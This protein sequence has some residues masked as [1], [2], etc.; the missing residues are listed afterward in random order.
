MIISSRVLVIY[1][2][3]S[4]GYSGDTAMITHL[5][6]LLCSDK[7]GDGMAWKEVPTFGESRK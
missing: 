6:Q 5:K 1:C 3:Y 4:F 7:S 2:G